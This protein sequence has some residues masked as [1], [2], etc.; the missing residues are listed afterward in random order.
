MRPPHLWC[1]GRASAPDL[2][3]LLARFARA[4]EYGQE[5]ESRFKHLQ[6]KKEVLP[7]I[8]EVMQS[9]LGMVRLMT[10]VPSAFRRGEKVRD[11]RS[12]A[13]HARSHS[14]R[15]RKNQADILAENGGIICLMSACGI[16]EAWCTTHMRGM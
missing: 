7:T 3:L 5:N 14:I 11:E 13:N 1:S 9:E 4:W 2:L 12:S 6:E 16:H 8:G 10:A 15:T